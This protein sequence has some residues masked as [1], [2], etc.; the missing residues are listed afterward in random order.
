[1][2]Y[3]LPE[4]LSIVAEATGFT[5]DELKG[6]RRFRRLTNAR[7]LYCYIARKNTSDSL[8]DIGQTINNR[9]HT[10]VIHSVNTIE[11]YIA[12]KDDLTLEHLKAISNSNPHLLLHIRDC[13]KVYA[14][15]YCIPTKWEGVM[16]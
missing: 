13:R 8:S 15:E 12:A 7:Q 6:S 5:V 14:G 11:G 3:T 16:N 9:D 10:T 4:I 1:M 2:N